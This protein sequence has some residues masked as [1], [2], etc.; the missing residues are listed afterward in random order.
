MFSPYLF[1]LTNT[2]FVPLQFDPSSAL[3]KE[4]MHKQILPYLLGKWVT[5]NSAII[6][7]KCMMKAG[8]YHQVTAQGKQLMEKLTWEQGILP[9]EKLLVQELPKDE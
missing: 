1:Q 5:H 2:N 7:L 6:N 8:S 9:M 3:I 4:L